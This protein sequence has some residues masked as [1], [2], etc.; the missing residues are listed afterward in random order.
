MLAQSESAS[1]G[2]KNK[3]NVEL[4]DECIVGNERR[5]ISDETPTMPNIKMRIAD[6][7]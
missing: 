6:E 1:L 2:G 5:D 7:A 4:G 3:W